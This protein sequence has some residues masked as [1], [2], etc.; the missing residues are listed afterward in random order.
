MASI[1]DVP[2]N[3]LIEKTAEELKKM[4]EFSPPEWARYVKTGAHKERV[5]ANRDWWYMR[6][7]S[8]LKTVYKLGPVGVSK[9]RTFYGGKKNRG[10]KPEKFYKGSGNII[11]KAMQQLEKA[12]FVKQDK[13]GVHKGRIITPKGRSFLDKI[14]TKILSGKPRIKKVVKKEIKKEEKKEI[15]EVKKEIKKEREEKKK[16]EKKEKITKKD[17]K[18]EVKEETKKEEEE[19]K[20]EKVIEKKKIKE[21][22]GKVK[23]KKET[24]EKKEEKTKIEVKK[25]VKKSKK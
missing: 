2:L 24:E 11:R 9:L 8:I 15:K 6:A 16:I 13:I 12:E 22:D 7:A 21:E 17:I 18:K 19:K 25:A 23:E 3:E 14:A 4:S 20:E 10:M 1:Y 5:P